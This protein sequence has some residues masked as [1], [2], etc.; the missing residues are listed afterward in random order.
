MLRVTG[1]SSSDQT[2][3]EGQFLTLRYVIKRIEDY[4]PLTLSKRTDIGLCRRQIIGDIGPH[5]GARCQTPRITLRIFSAK[6]VKT[7]PS[8]IFGKSGRQNDRAFWNTDKTRVGCN[9]VMLFHRPFLFLDGL[10][11]F[12]LAIGITPSFL[13]TV[14]GAVLPTTPPFHSHSTAT[15]P[16]ANRVDRTAKVGRVQI[17]E[18]IFRRLRSPAD[19]PCR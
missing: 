1:K 10:K 6:R 14:L 2:V 16:F 19:A 3:V 4:P 11:S 5:S 13:P 12:S 9:A 18:Q 8:A 7:G 15:R 17:V